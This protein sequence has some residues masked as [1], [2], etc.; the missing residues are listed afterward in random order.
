MGIVEKIDKEFSEWGCLREVRIDCGASW[1]SDLKPIYRDLYCVVVKKDRD[2]YMV[3]GWVNMRGGMKYFY[4]QAN[5][6]MELKDLG[7]W[8]DDN[9]IPSELFIRLPRHD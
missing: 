5:D 8:A 4:A 1:R 7:F 2:S 3:R 6:N 9:L